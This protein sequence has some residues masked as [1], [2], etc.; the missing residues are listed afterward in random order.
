TVTREAADKLIVKDLQLR[1]RRALDEDLKHV[2]TLAVDRGGVV[3]KLERTDNGGFRLI[4]PKREGLEADA[5]LATDLAELATRLVVVR[6]VAE[7]DDGAFGLAKPRLTID[8]GLA[9]AGAGARD[10]R[11]ELGAPAPDGS[12]AR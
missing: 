3:Q 4:E 8:V 5:G 11:I 6:W 2:K 1:P 9:D 12:F 10:M 7:H